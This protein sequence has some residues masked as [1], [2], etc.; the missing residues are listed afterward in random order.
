MFEAISRSKSMQLGQSLF[1]KPLQSIE[2]AAS[3]DS[4]STFDLTATIRLSAEDIDELT[5]LIAQTVW[6]GEKGEEKGARN[7]PALSILDLMPHVLD[8]G[9]DVRL[10]RTRSKLDESLGILTHNAF[11]PSLPPV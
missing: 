1:K 7:R 6:G 10:L 9:V 11:L 5:E 4:Q 8:I 3:K 2:L